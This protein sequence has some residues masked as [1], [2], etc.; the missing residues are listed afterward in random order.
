[1]FASLLFVLL[2]T[3]PGADDPALGDARLNDI[4]FVDSQHG[5]AVG[6]RGVIWS[7]ED[8]GRAWRLQ[9]SGVTCSL[10]GVCF[11]DAHLGWAVGGFTHPYTHA[12][13]GVLLTTRDGGQT[14]AG[15]SNLVLPALRR[16]GFFDPQHGWAIGCP[17]A[18]Y[19][20]GVFVTEDGG[21]RW[22]PL[23][24][25]TGWLTGALLDPRT[26]ALAGR[27]GS[28]AVVN[29]GEIEVLRADQPSLQNIVQMRLVAPAHGWL[30]GDGG[31]VRMT[32]DLGSTW[33]A[34]PGSLPPAVRQ[35]DFAAL[36]TRGVKCWLA[37]TPGTRV[38]HSADAGRTW[39]VFATGSAVPLRAM[40]F[41]DD[42]HGWAVGDLGTILATGDGGRTW[43][44]QRAGGTR[45]A[46][47]GMFAD[48][49]DVPL[50]LIASLAGNE[51][52]FAIID[53]LGRRDVEM[54]SRDDV[55]PADRLHEAVVRV[56]GCGAEAAWQFPLRQT[57]LCLG[58][59]QIVAP[60]DDVNDG[61][62]ME[63]LRAHVVRQI[64]LWRPEVMVTHDAGR[65]G[66]DPLISL[67][68][69]AVLQAVQQAADRTAFAGQIADLGL[70]PW[71][72]RKVF[73]AL[74][75]GMRGSSDLITTQFAPRLG[76]SLADAAAEP[77]GLLQD[78]F[79]RAPPMLGFRL[80]ASTAG[81]EQDRR[82]YFGGIVLPPGSVARRQL[83]QT[84]LEN[85]DQRQRIA[86]KRRHVQAILEHAERTVASVEQLLAQVD[87]LTRN[88][89]DDSRGQILYQ[90][91]DR[92]AHSGRWALAA[93][94]FQVLTERY[95]QHA[96]ASSAMLW[97]LQYYAS[98]EAAWR[99]ERGDGQ[100][101]FA[102][103]VSLGQQFERIR[104]EWFAEPAVCFPLAAAYRN[105]GQAR[106]AERFYQV[107]SHRG[108]RD[109]WS[110]CAQSELFLVEPKAK[111]RLAKPVLRCARSESRPHLDGL[112]DDPVWQRAKPAALQS[113][114]HD[115]GDW[116]AE[117]ML[118]YDA[119]F[120]YVAV[121][122]REA[123]SGSV[124]SPAS[125]AAVRV[126]DA[127][128]SAH[129]RIE[130]LIDVDRDYTTYY[131]LAIDHRGWTN[132][133]CW[134]DSTWDP[135]W[136]VAAKQGDGVWTA[137][138]AIPLAE[139]TGRPPQPRDTWAIGIQRVVP[140]TGFQSWTTPAAISVLPDG[141]GYLVFQ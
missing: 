72:V 106:Q 108:D 30:A 126:R 135:K 67:I 74:P 112:L 85:L 33:K 19:P 35:F 2:S 100:P 20:S 6:D 86:Q 124:S 75:A 136:F 77:R 117:V 58:P 8:G 52:Y 109:A 44:P 14:W 38:F 24:G 57:G 68:H 4:C 91:A 73:G 128:L 94:T 116:P 122:C 5:W 10:E 28:L 22:R 139:L 51:G 3:V 11:G 29:R 123:P 54:P 92:Y 134:G 78:R 26:G 62:G 113:A 65:P 40:T 42:D 111:G 120:L 34:P 88:L 140:G 107:Q 31:L 43:Q 137:E 66:D 102:R 70:E 1:M 141:F 87:D 41:S 69:Q 133:S 90:L 27:N 82:D 131:R 71:A 9:P 89:D 110:V 25:G 21:R 7:T 80:L 60:W 96:L 56:G 129:D 84:P 17:S 105:Q 79:A 115:D 45:A 37:G 119:E 55:H 36:A 47:L 50:E 99:V 138:A 95:P 39:N 132:D 76:R 98:G 61:R 114:Q 103:A 49:D 125:P 97:L 18:I 83:P 118:A 59:P 53:L 16:L 101:R 13:T 46:L 93:E 48:P 121:H 64:R 130:I 81:Q 63:A 104:P 32:A 15:N 12:S 23:P 127:D